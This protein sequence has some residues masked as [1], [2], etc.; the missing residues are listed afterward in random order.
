MSSAPLVA[1]TA[2]VVGC[3]IGSALALGHAHA[4]P[5]PARPEAQRLA[6]SATAAPALHAQATWTGKRAAPFRLSD[7]TGKPLSLD[8][9]RGRLVLLTF[10]DSRCRSQ[11]PIEGG[12]L[13]ALGR[14]LG[15]SPRIVLLAVSVDPWRD[16]PASA[17][18]FAAKARWTLDWH[19]LFGTPGELKPVWAAY[20]ESVH[21]LKICVAPPGCVFDVTHTLMLY[22]LDA[23]GDQRAAYL[24]PFS[25]AE[26][27]SDVRKIAAT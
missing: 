20:G 27:A 26:V 15:A 22:V 9:L 21:R 11:C 10:L 17:R 5:V 19:W 23:Q 8:S 2:V 4:R 25:P 12:M 24:Y 14:R 13:A 3:G 1:A 16:T 6:S 7:E 18:A